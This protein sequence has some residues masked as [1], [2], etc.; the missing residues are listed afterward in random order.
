[1]QTKD[2]Q[3]FRFSSICESQTQ[4]RLLSRASANLK[5][6]AMPDSILGKT[7]IAIALEMDGKNGLTPQSFVVTKTADYIM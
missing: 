4:R 2:V 5:N 3:A 7:P 1:M 6:E